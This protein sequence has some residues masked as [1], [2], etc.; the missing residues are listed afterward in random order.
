MSPTETSLPDHSQGDI[1]VCDDTPASLKLLSSLLTDAG[2]SVRPANS[3]EL[4]LQSAFAKAPELILLDIRMPGIDGYD[5]CRRLK[6]N[7]STSEVPVMFI[8]ALDD[9]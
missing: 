9:V 2:Y 4:A 5:V 3:G 1:L 8:S 7:E 6:E